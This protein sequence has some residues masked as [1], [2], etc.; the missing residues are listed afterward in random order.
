MTT[1]A[2]L[3]ASDLSALSRLLDEALDLA[4]GAR[5]AWLAALPAPAQP[6]R[7]LLAEMLA[8]QQSGQHAAFMA[9]GPRWA[10]SRAAE[11][12]AQP[13]DL[14]G[15]YRLQRLL[16][17]GGMCSVWLAERADAA[18]SRS[19][20]LKMPLLHW[21]S[22]SQI[23]RFE[24]ERE[25]LGR[26]NHPQIARLY[27]AG[28]ALTGQPYLVMEFVA[29]RPITDACDAAQMA[30]AAR[31]R[32]FL[33]VLA[34]VAHAHRHLV[35]HRDIKPS[36]VF[37][38]GQGQVKLLDF[39]IAKL[40]QTPAGAAAA[41]ALTRDGGNVLTP[42]HA[43]PEQIDGG[44]ISTATDVYGLG[45]L[46]YE[47]LAGALPHAQAQ[48]SMAHA[49]QAVLHHPPLPPSQA[50]LGGSVP[51][52]R[53]AAHAAALRAQLAGDLDTIVL[54][55]LRTAPAERYSSAERMADDIAR[56]LDHRPI[57]ARP[58]SPGRRLQLFVR[59][60]R[61]AAAAS[62]I[63]GVAAL[64][65][66]G[67]LG[68]Q[69]ARTADQQGRAD[70]VREFMLDMVESA[71]ADESQP[72][73]EV[74]GRQMVAGGLRRAHDRF[75]GQPLLLGEVLG[76]LG[77]MFDRFGDDPQAQA[78]LTEAAALLDAHAP[79]D[80]PAR[81]KTR[82]Q[83]ANRALAANDLTRAQALARTAHDACGRPDAECAKARAYASALL[84]NLAS[85]Q[86]RWPE[87]VRLMRESVTDTARGF[88]ARHAE[89]ALAWHDLALIARDAGD[90]QEADRAL[91]QA[92]LLAEHAVLHPRDRTM[93][94][95]SQAVLA[96]DLG[97]YS[98][99]RAGLLSLIASPAEP[100]ERALQWRLLANT[101][102]AMG[103]GD[104]AQAAA[105]QALAMAP[106][107]ASTSI[108]TS[109]STPTA[110]PTPTSVPTSTST[111]TSAPAPA[112]A[113]AGAAAADAASADPEPLFAHQAHARA[114]GLLGRT[115]PALAELR[116]VLQGLP[117][118]GYGPT[119]VPVLRAQRFLAELLAQHGD[120]AA[121][122][123]ESER[124]VATLALLS[125]QGANTAIEL[126]QTLDLQGRIQHGLHHPAEAAALH[127][128]AGDLLRRQLPAA[129]PL[130]AR[131][132]LALDQARL[133]A[134]AAPA[135]L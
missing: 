134:A 50:P 97:R 6:W 80:E 43:A 27:D 101:E 73:T 49:V 59:R 37:V 52:R 31:L 120:A 88:G 35:V 124:V 114:L 17:Q 115:A 10:D 72:G 42:R 48:R 127:R 62:A 68:L 91:A 104:A 46:L 41:S 25:V 98:A 92:A 21:R 108:S 75:A 67:L 84:G 33:Q 7:A 112:P 118:T 36:N 38:D 5:P 126:G 82:V 18:P 122:W 22:S 23:L 30:V 96:L 54:K 70:A 15:P 119:S 116:A 105:D 130:L 9:D 100:A 20:A 135:T 129:H 79:E 57:A 102:L 39:G 65:L 26:L 132:A 90:L 3:T 1:P 131:N 78:A 53:G 14:I 12:A 24:Q 76:A 83:L 87:A 29:G 103:Q 107:P 121:A 94:Q 77:R 117:A 110:T 32:V 123:A 85:R 71:E 111:S 2:H 16:G 99:A 44:P 40:L 4:P 19:V 81:N 64:L 34:A 51:A 56:H 125:T 60:H 13:G 28:V 128:R 63:G 106:T 74:T 66:A 93:L 113:P 89:T 11:P 133:A 69:H 8:A 58:P 61:H 45:V 95:R 109:T 55:A 86:G 47:L